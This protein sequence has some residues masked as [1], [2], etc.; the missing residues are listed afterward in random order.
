MSIYQL[1]KLGKKYLI[2]WPEKSELANYF[3]EY[4][5]IQLSRLVCRYFPRLALLSLV[6]QLYFGSL[7]ILPQ[8]VMYALFILTMPIQTL[9]MLG[10]K[11]DQILPP[12]LALWYRETIAKVN[13]NGGTMKLSMNN[14][15]YLD[16]ALLL[17]LSYQQ[18]KY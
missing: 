15:R 6:L 3:P 13:E 18:A 9:L 11:A 10:L 8:A 12:S 17:K 16:L 5:V 1:I 7:A 14:P 2:L 4:R